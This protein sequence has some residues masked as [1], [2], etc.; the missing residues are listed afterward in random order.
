V[1]LGSAGV[2]LARE[3]LRTGDIRES[4]RAAVYATAGV[5]STAVVQFVVTLSLLIAF[6]TALVL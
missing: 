5:L 4:S 6:V 3:L 2:V 1:L